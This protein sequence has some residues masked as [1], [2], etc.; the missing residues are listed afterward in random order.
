VAWLVEI[1]QL[2]VGQGMGGFAYLYDTDTDKAEHTIL[3]DL[4][5][6]STRTITAPSVEWV[7]AGLKTWMAQ[8][9]IDLAILSH[10]DKD[11]ISLITN[12]LKAFKPY[13]PSSGQT[14]TDTLSVG[15]VAYS[16]YKDMYKKG[17]GPNVL[18]ELKRYMVTNPVGEREPIP[19]PPDFSSFDPATGTATVFRTVGPIS[20]YFLIGN[21]GHVPDPDPPPDPLPARSKDANLINTKSLVTVLSYYGGQIV[22]PGDAT[23]ATMM[24]CNSKMTPAIKQSFLNKVLITAAPHHGAR[25]TALGV[26][27]TSLGGITPEQNLVD[28]AGNL[29]ANSVFASAGQV[30]KYWHP[31]ADILRYFWD[32]LPPNPEFFFR[33]EDLGDRHF[34]TA[35]FRPED[36]FYQLVKQKTRVNWPRQNAW[37]TVQTEANVFTNTYYVADY[38]QDSAYVVPPNPFESIPVPVTVVSPPK[39]LPARGV[40]WLFTQG[41]DFG[42]VLTPLTNR[43]SLLRLRAAIL[44]GVSPDSLPDVP[45]EDVEQHRSVY[46]AGVRGS[47]HA[48]RTNAARVR[49]VGARRGLRG[50]E[51]VP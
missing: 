35:Y 19:V 26:T 1:A 12:L 17:K 43:A 15:Y 51:Q 24:S 5:S 18:D 11:H 50:L 34:Y 40:A 2:D 42:P 44:V 28:Y 29:R 20:V 6:A 30:K 3:F 37:F 23:A 49:T 10:S 25:D 39:T 31:Y 33:H 7:V 14:G 8:P 48:G 16:G 45:S 36:D 32:K 38:A 21:V 41:T 4:G 9:K 47:G 27:P 13:D 46:P 22:M